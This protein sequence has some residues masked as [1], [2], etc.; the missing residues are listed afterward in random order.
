MSGAAV[1]MFL[2]QLHQLHELVATLSAEQFATYEMNLCL[3]NYAERCAH[4]NNLEMRV[5]SMECLNDVRRIQPR[6]ALD[7]VDIANKMLDFVR[8]EQLIADENQIVKHIRRV[9]MMS[10]LVRSNQLVMEPDSAFYGSEELESTSEE[11][12][13]STIRSPSPFYDWVIIEGGDINY[14]GDDEMEDDDDDI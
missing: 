13:A 3:L 7:R 10:E 8:F 9:A 4:A 1:E 12:S 6:F 11:E 14:E 5:I 2:N